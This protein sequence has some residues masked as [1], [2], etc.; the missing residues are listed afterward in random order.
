[1]TRLTPEGSRRLRLVLALAAIV[2][3]LLWVLGTFRRGRIHGGGQP[4]VDATAAPLHTQ[5]VVLRTVTATT[6][7]VGTVQ[8]EQL[9][10]LTSRVVANIVEMRSAAGQRVAAGTPLVQLDD[11]EL[12]HRLEQARSARSSAEATLAQA[13]SDYQRDQPVFNQGGLS[14]YEFEHTQ[15]SL[16]IAEANLRRS[17]EAERE[18]EVELSYAVVRSPFAG[19]VVDR[20]ANQGEQAAPG[21]PLLTMYQEGRL[22]LEVQVPEALMGRIHLRDRL[23]FRIDALDRDLRGQVVEIVPSSDPSSRSVVARVRL[24]DT[25][26][27]L[28]GMFGRLQLPSKPEP[29]LILPDSAVIRAGQLTLVDVVRNG[30]V[31]R[32]SVQ[33]GRAADGKVEVLSGLSAGETVVDGN[34]R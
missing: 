24:Q 15:T 8:A 3:L 17:Q 23:P 28:P 9:A 21:K 11:R 14:A 20:L 26:D 7:L 32:R 30:R 13:R 22:W 27:V 25:R 19:I 5:P 31:E 18:A 12:R 2:I 1:M 16:R 29:R 10:S 6:E 4:H 33:L 34:A